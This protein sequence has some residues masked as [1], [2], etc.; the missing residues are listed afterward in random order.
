MADNYYQSAYSGAQIDEAVGRI[1]NKE[2]DKLAND[3]IIAAANAESAK[4][5]AVVAEGNSVSAESGAV[6]AKNEA[7]KAQKAAEQ[8]RDEAQQ[9]SGGDF[10]TPAY[11]QNQIEQITAA[12]VGAVPI[13]G[14]STITSGYDTPLTLH[15]EN[16][17]LK[18]VYLCYFLNGANQ[19]YIGFKDGE[20]NIYNKGK[21]LHTGNK[22]SGSYTGN[23][24]AT[25]RTISIGG[26]GGALFLQGGG[27]VLIVG[28]DGAFGASYD[29]NSVSLSSSVCK[30][31]DGV[32]TV[33]GT[34][35]AIN[36]SQLEYKYQVL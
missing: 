8:A 26:I 4:N 7:L 30:F 35:V 1:V 11:V 25:A 29:G 28:Q 19:G 2:I 9:I 17:S 18:E 27:N 34:H 22:P 6:T 23:G 21:I 10:A 13:R 32:L 5:R 12:Q 14:K 16:A 24:D 31:K 3:A 36:A 20:A 33:A 15:A